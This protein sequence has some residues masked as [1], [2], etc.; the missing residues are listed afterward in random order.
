MEV[1]ERVLREGG[2]EYRFL[3]LSRER[4]GSRLLRLLTLELGR[5]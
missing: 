4:E 2:R 5:R 1:L 3:G